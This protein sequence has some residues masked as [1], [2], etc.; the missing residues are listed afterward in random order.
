MGEMMDE[1]YYEKT[2][3]YQNDI[4]AAARANSLQ[5]KPEIVKQAN[6]YLLRFFSNTTQNGEILLLRPNNS[7]QDLAIPLK[8]NDRG[9]Q[10][11]HAVKLIDGDYEAF[12]RWKQDG[13]DY[14]IKKTLHWQ[15]PSS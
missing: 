6:G 4:D 13:R 7:E 2:I 15:D 8:L 10:L 1:D 3:K 12:I 9:E 11:I 14:L 5:Q